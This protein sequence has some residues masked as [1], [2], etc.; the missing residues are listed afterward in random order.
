MPKRPVRV[1]C[2][3]DN[4][5][6][7][8]K[9]LASVI[10]PE[11]IEFTVRDGARPLAI[12]R[13]VPRP[14]LRKYRTSLRAGLA[15][16][17]TKYDLL[18]SFGPVMTCLT[19]LVTRPCRRRIP[20]LAFAFNYTHLPHGKRR[21]LGELAFPTVDRFVVASSVERRL[22]SEYFALDPDRFDVLLWGIEKPAV[23]AG[24]PPFIPGDYVCALGGEGRDY[25][26]LLAAAELVPHIPIA[27]V[28]RPYSLPARA[29]P[30]NVELHVGLT[31][32]QCWN[33][34]Q[35]SQLSVVALRD[36]EVPCG[37]VTLVSSMHHR[38][39]LVVTD[40]EGVHDYVR[41]EDNALLVPPRDP[42]AMAIAIERLFEDR[43]CAE[44]LAEAGHRFA[45]SHCREQTTVSYLRQYVAGLHLA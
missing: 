7:S 20:H 28:T 27:I 26:V 3:S 15:S 16:V 12:E 36:S 34:L 19:E 42:R 13:F 2:S 6:P 29:I 30:A 40:S 4:S 44:R 25:D 41:H 18:V 21:T 23:P 32:A 11:E 14:S 5:D 31:G 33:V 38:K 1:L 43:A 8:W 35:H 39:A 37:H 10:P 45:A 9:W 17:T 24:E 22:Y